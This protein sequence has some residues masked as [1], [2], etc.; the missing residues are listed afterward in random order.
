M[1]LM[2]L[3]LPHELLLCIIQHLQDVDLARF[4]QVCHLFRV[5]GNDG[6]AWRSLFQSRWLN[7]T[8]AN[9]RQMYLRMVCAEKYTVRKY[10]VCSA[11]V[12]CLDWV[13]PDIFVAG[14]A[15][16]SLRSCQVPDGAQLRITRHAHGGRVRCITNTAT[17]STPLTD[18]GPTSA[19]ASSS[20]CLIVTGGDD[21][22]VRLWD[23]ASLQ[24]VHSIHGRASMV[25]CV[26]V[27]GQH[28]ILSTDS[29]NPEHMIKMFDLN[30]GQCV[31]AFTGHALPVHALSVLDNQLLSAGQ[32]SFAMLWDL[33]SAT[34]IHTFRGHS[35]SV[36]SVFL[37]PD[38]MWLITGSADRSVREWDRRKNTVHR[39]L[40]AHSTVVNGVYSDNEKVVS[41]SS[42]RTLKEWCRKSSSWRNVCGHTDAL[43]GLCVRGR[44]MATCSDDGSVMLWQLYY[45]M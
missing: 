24:C 10:P 26:Q 35:A 17:A 1:S 11:G 4:S 23:V 41:I 45:P 12:Q 37:Q 39:N 20:Q 38:N 6:L 27:S 33:R 3:Q 28:L 25:S 29:K 36:A 19:A 22:I 18:V 31:T 5:L 13:T 14:C 7:E 30:T 2:L 9:Y 16:G 21:G 44:Q 43:R 40:N 42:D 34:A 32:E 15:D 8:A